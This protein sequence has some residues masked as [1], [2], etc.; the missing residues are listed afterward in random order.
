VP[1][2]PP[3]KL[4]H[5][6]ATLVKRGFW[7]S[8]GGILTRGVSQSRAG[9][10]AEQASLHTCSDQQFYQ[11]YRPPDTSEEQFCLLYLPYCPPDN[12]EHV[13]A[14]LVQRGRWVSVGKVLERGVGQSAFE[15]AVSDA[16]LHAEDYEFSHNILPHC[17]HELQ[18]KVLETLA[19]RR[20]E[21]SV[22][23]VLK[24][25]V[26]EMSD[27]QRWMVVDYF[28]DGM[29][30]F[31]DFNTFA[32][33]VLPRLG[34]STESILRRCVEREKGLTKEFTLQYMFLQDSM[35]RSRDT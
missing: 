32:I 25:C 19:Q 5:V 20:L 12:L 23:T 17:S 8:A 27:T 9:W 28:A 33:I 29:K 30:T 14:T 4:E 34:L 6:L 16:S 21:W 22:G 31:A 26:K 1:N 13:L 35:L 7:I 2:C 3:D 24:T 11:M 18:L 10:A 15:A